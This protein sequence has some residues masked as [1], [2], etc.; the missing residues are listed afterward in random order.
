MGVRIRKS[1]LK[2]GITLFFLLSLAVMVGIL[3]WTTESDTWTLLGRFRPEF[4]P[5]LFGLAALRWMVD[6]M[7]FVTM[8]KDHPRKVLTLRRA[9]EIRLQGSLVANVLPVVLGSF[10]MHTYLLNKE[11]LNLSESM[12]MTVLRAV[13]PVFIFLVNIP[14]LIFLGSDPRQETLFLRLMEVISLPMALIIVFFTYTLFFPHRIKKAA[15][16]LIRWWGRTRIIHMERVI[17]WEEKTFREV[18]QFSRILWGYLRHRRGVIFRSAGWLSSAFLID[19]LIGLAIIWGF[20]IHPPWLYAVLLQC[21][22]RP[23]IYLAPTPGGAGVWD[24]TYLGFFALYLPQSI[25]G[26]AVLIWRLLI[27][28]LPALA[29]AL[30]LVHEFRRDRRLKNILEKRGVFTDEELILRGEKNL[31]SSGVPED[32]R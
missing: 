11:R 4:I 14:I 20:G 13:L 15:S 24:L 7:A 30:V 26:V 18:D 8:V 12:A 23:I 6:G 5:L 17:A 32:K 2:K 21:L 1:V 28:Y 29:G 3:L 10:T 25:I 27:S 9:V 16:A 22:M 31:G 19:Y